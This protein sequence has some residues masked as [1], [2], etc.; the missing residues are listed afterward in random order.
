MSLAFEVVYY[1]VKLAFYVLVKELMQS[2]S[3]VT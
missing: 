1:L 2:K 3:K